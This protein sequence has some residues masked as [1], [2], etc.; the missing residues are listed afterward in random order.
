LIMLAHAAVASAA[1]AACPFPASLSTAIATMLSLPPGTAQLVG[2]MADLG[3]P[4]QATD[5][6]PAG[7]HPP[8]SRFVSAEGRGCDLSVN[9][10]RGGI[11]H[12]WRTTHL[13]FDAGKWVVVNR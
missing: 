4:F 7:K 11:A 9:Y 12:S 5:V 10:E 3:E 13:R 6:L 8:F 1:T 2:D